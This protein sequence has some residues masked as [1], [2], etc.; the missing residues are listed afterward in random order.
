MGKLPCQQLSN[1]SSN[2]VLKI[3]DTFCPEEKLYYSAKSVEKQGQIEFTINA[4]K[5]SGLVLNS[6]DLPTWAGIQSLISLAE[7][8]LMQCGFLPFIPHP[9]TD[10]S[11]VYTAMENFVGV[12]SQLEQDHLPVF[13]AE[14]VFRIV[15]DIYLKFPHTFAIGRFSHHQV[16]SPLHW[17]ICKR[18]WAGRFSNRNKGV[19]RKGA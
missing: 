11:T 6:S 16:C 9:V 12:A 5:N 13:C 19:R 17:Q 7:L 10:H 3:P 15:L 14:G 1:F 8:P 18:Q 4:L 2:K